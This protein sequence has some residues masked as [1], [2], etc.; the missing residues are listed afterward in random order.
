[1]TDNTD[2]I[3]DFT[4]IYNRFKKK[5]YNYVLKM[6]QDIMLT[7]DIVQNIFLKLF[8]NIYSIRYKENI[9]YWLFTTARNE[10]YGFYR[11]KRIS[12]LR[13]QLCSN[14]DKKSGG[15]PFHVNLN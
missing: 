1:L 7:E 13:Y 4:L 15:S 9:N 8:Q 10:V 5:L 3:V 11:R 12:R 6:T 14:C 2:H